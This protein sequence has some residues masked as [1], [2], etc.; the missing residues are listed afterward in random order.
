MHIFLKNYDKLAIGKEQPDSQDACNRNL[1]N[2]ILYDIEPFNHKVQG[3][4][5]LTEILQN[6]H[7]E[8]NKKLFLQFFS[9]IEIFHR[10]F[11]GPN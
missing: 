5:E 11:I 3:A 2:E 1:I 9:I 10:F 4:A 8:V 7:L 6:P